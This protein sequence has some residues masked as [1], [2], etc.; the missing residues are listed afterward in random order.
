MP[1]LRSL[2]NPDHLYDPRLVEVQFREQRCV[3]IG[4]D[5]AGVIGEALA[6]NLHMERNNA[7]M[8]EILLATVDSVRGKEVVVLD[9]EGV[10]VNVVQ[11]PQHVQYFLPLLSWLASPKPWLK[12]Q[13]RPC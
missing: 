8:V 11:K 2:P 12:R 4:P 7:A 5:C 13:C 10:V 1:W 9:D 6:E 3:T